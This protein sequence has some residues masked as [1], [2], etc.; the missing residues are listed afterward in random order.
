MMMKPFI[1][2]EVG[3]NWFKEDDL[4]RSIVLAK[5]CGA[6][7]V[8][9]QLFTAKEL[10]GFHTPDP[11]L[12]KYALP[13]GWIPRLKEKCDASKIEFMCTAF[14]VEGLHLVNRYV[15]RHKLASS[16]V[17]HL[18][19]LELLSK[20][21]KATYVS[22]GGK[23]TADLK[24]ALGILREIDSTVL[25]CVANYPARIVDLREIGRLR[26][27]LGVPVGYSDHTTDP[28]W[29][30]Q[31]AV[32]HYEAEV[33]EKHVNFVG[34]SGPDSPHSINTEEFKLMCDILKDPDAPINVNEKDMALKWNRRIIATKHIVA[35][36]TM[37]EDFN[38]GIHRSLKSDTKGLHPFHIPRLSGKRA[39][40]AIQKG[41][42]ISPDMIDG[43]T[44]TSTSESEKPSG[45]S[46]AAN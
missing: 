22:S 23:S 27:E 2:A 9:F 12:K 36:Q 32:H 30:P 26:H 41:D 19:M 15:T 16:D 18:R 43:W 44:T 8:K 20:F 40:R 38:I 11:N 29:I 4:F 28:L 31:L 1:V 35:N 37:E 7:A 5:T 25:Y 46:L 45:D 13:P 6:D 21:G 39:K 14:S 10:Y 3:S 24:S 34:S 17:L 42:A 33:I